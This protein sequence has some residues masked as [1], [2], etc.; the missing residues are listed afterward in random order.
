MSQWEG[1][2][3]NVHL[4]IIISKGIGVELENSICSLQPGGGA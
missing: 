3:Y 1:S 4:Y 2:I